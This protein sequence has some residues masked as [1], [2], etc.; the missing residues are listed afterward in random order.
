LAAIRAG[1]GQQLGDVV[2]PLTDL[3]VPRGRVVGHGAQAIVAS[4]SF[5]AVP[6]P[7]DCGALGG[8][9]DLNGTL[10]I[11]LRGSPPSEYAGIAYLSSTADLSGTDVA[12]FLALTHPPAPARGAVR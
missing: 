1:D 5:T 9:T 8:V 6:L 7:L 10:T 2:A 11:G 3:S 4:P 12:V